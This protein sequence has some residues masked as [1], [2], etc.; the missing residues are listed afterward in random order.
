MTRKI[1]REIQRLAPEASVTTNG[2]NHYEVRL[3]NGALVIASNTPSGQFYFRK[4]LADIRRQSRKR[5]IKTEGDS[6]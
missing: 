1:L 5:S 2:R 3:P 4:L 6:P